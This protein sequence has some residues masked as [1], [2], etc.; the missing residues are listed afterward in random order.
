M[1]FNPD[2]GGIN[3][4][5][6]LHITGKIYQ[7]LPLY[8]GLGTTGTYIY[9]TNYNVAGHTCDIT[10]ESQVHNATAD[11][12]SPRAT[13]TLSCAVV[14]KDGILC[15]TFKGDG[16]VIPSGE[17]AV[18]TATGPLAN[19]RFWSPD[20]PYLYDV[21]TILT[22]N[23]KV[24]DVVKTTTGF[25]KTEFK[26]GAGTGGVYINDKFVYL[27][28][29]AQ[30]TSDEWA[31]IGAG[32]PIGC[33]ISPHN[34]FVIATEITSGGCTS[35]RKRW[36]SK[37]MTVSASSRSPPRATRKRMRKGANGISAW[38]LCATPSSIS[39]TIPAFYSGRRETP[40]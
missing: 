1:T 16:V 34:W 15:A 18:L 5:V 33:T 39:A 29:F 36:T 27:K 12:T 25:R 7:T 30:R 13:V 28:G 31:G 37:P 3:R 26:G 23:G 2:H 38:R 17:K 19:A 14:D 40:G 8:Y 4:R 6:W 11:R 22:V 35:L 20:D 21:Y 24:V 9:G 10:V 32:I